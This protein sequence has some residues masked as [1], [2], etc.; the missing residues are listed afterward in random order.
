MAKKKEPY[1]VV[2]T[3]LTFCDKYKID[4]IANKFGMTMYELFQCL[5]LCLLRYFDTDT[6][7]ENDS[8]SFL[9]YFAESILN[10]KD[11]YNPIS[12]KQNNVSVLSAIVILSKKE[13]KRPQTIAVKVD[14]KG[15]L[16]E[17]YN[18]D[19]MLEDFLNATDTK[20]LNMLQKESIKDRKFSIFQTLH[21]G[22]CEYFKK[23]NDT[24]EEDIKELFSDIR[25][26][27]GK[28]INNDIYYNRKFNSSVEKHIIETNKMKRKKV[29]F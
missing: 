14:E 3:K 17:S 19:K 2:A 1:C 12:L 11:S 18:I 8:H 28:E 4:L 15:N 6:P 9:R 20:L 22:F 26:Q 21:D 29:E 16:L 27:S 10:S 24:L 5:L 13:K 7:I 23:H 25:I